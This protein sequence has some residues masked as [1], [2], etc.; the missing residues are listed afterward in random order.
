[1]HDRRESWDTIRR[2]HVGFSNYVQITHQASMKPFLSLLFYKQMRCN[3]YLLFIFIFVNCN[4]FKPIYCP[5]SIHCANGTA[6]YIAFVSH[7]LCFLLLI[8]LPGFSA[9][10]GC[11]GNLAARVSRPTWLYWVG[12]S[13]SCWLCYY[14]P[15]WWRTSAVEAAGSSLMPTLSRR[16]I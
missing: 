7:C 8:G 15:A 14:V 1:M 16:G 6:H 11:L 10:V 3:Y 4:F 5:C 13:G 9:C 2:R 12:R